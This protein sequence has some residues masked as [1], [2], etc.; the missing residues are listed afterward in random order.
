MRTIKRILIAL[1]VMALIA[2]GYLDVVLWFCLG[3]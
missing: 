1:G 3:R 2:V